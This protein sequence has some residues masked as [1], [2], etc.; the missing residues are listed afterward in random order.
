MTLGPLAIPRLRRYGTRLAVVL[1]SV[2]LALGLG[3]WA[4]R[5]L[6]PAF[7][8]SG[9]VRLVRQGELVL[10]VPDSRA[11]QRKNTGDYDVGVR[12]GP[13]GFRDPR[14]VA[15]AQP[16][17]LLVVGDSFAFG[18]GVEED[19]R[20]SNRLEVLSGQRSFNIAMPGQNLDGYDRL[21][22]HA[23]ALGSR[24]VHLIVSLCM[25]NDVGTYGEAGAMLAEPPPGSLSSAG[26]WIPVAK[27]GLG[28]H[29]ALYG[30]ITEAVHRTPLLERLAERLGLVQPNLGA[31]GT[32]LVTEQSVAATA[33]RL[34]VLARGYETTVL[35]VPSR[36]LWIERSA[37][38]ADRLHRAMVAALV[39]RGLAVV[40][41]R[42]AFEAGGEPLA[43]HFANDGHWNEHGHRIAA[44]CLAH[45]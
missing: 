5:R 16:S 40:D 14:D 22:R 31:V 1:A 33:D 3:E 13:R 45:R 39:G 25:E 6:F 9:Q 24:S 36:A 27:L 4:V 34:A 30:L 28:E 44:E 35:L 43:V 18:W 8:P 19:E 32:R 26:S 29:S 20:W 38:E 21:L 10:G 42:A 15:E 12:F 37:V 17:D 7:D 2:L 41:P 23:R 11:R